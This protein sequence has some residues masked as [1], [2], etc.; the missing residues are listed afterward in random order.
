MKYYHSDCQLPFSWVETASTFFRRYP[1]TFSKHVLSEDVISRTVGGVLLLFLL[2]LA[3]FFVQVDGCTLRTVRVLS[4]TN[5]MP[6]W[7]ERYFGAHKHL[8]VVEESVV[9][10]KT[11]LV[12]LIAEFTRHRAI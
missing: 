7:G 1:N 4:K 2:T 5:R 10:T 11:K 9:N 3:I 6:R 12:E 8:L